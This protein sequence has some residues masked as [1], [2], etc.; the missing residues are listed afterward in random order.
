MDA[1]LDGGGATKTSIAP[2]RQKPSRRHCALHM[3]LDNRLVF[4]NR[5]RSL[6]SIQS[7]FSKHIEHY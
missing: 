7:R 3:Q 4:I 5:D 2:G 6:L 1:H